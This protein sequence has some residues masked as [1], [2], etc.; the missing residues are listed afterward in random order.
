MSNPLTVGWLI[1]RYIKLRGRT[2]KQ[3]AADLKY[4]YTTFCGLLNRD[5]V[6]ANLLFKLANLLDMDLA[7]MAELFD[8]KKP[9]SSLS[10]YQMSRMQHDFREQ[11][12]APIRNQLDECIRNNPNS[13]SEARKELISIY[14][15]V[16]YLLD[17]LLPEEYVIRITIERGK[18]KLY[19]FPL[20]DTP[21][22]VGGRGRSANHF[23]EG[24]EM[25]NQIIAHRKEE[26]L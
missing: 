8:G 20:S 12:L 7:W 1:K 18:E 22:L 5:A 11:N 3:V 10:P 6:D 16:F 23:Y 21:V 13:I 17:M 19:C 9:I 25:L 26:L 4:P 14:H 15:N 24:N 2:A